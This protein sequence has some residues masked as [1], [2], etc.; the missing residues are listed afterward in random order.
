MSAGGGGW[1]PDPWERHEQRWHNGREWTTTVLD[2]GVRSDESVTAAVPVL[3]TLPAAA[4]QSDAALSPPPLQS[5][6]TVRRRTRAGS[7]AKTVARGVG[8][9]TL[10]IGAVAVVAAVASPSEDEAVAVVERTD[11]VPVLLGPGVTH[12]EA[13]VDAAGFGDQWPLLV[14]SGTVVCE[15]VP[16]PVVVEAVFFVDQVG[17][18]YAVNGAAKA[19]TETFDWPDIESIWREH[20]SGEDLRMNIGPLIDAGR[21]ICEEA[22]VTSE[23]TPADLISASVEITWQS[24]T[25]EDRRAQC[26]VWN[27]DPEFARSAFLG[28]SPELEDY[29]TALE[30]LLVRDC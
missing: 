11:V 17:T 5:H 16:G 25:L 30:A 20:P 22:E 10:L 6:A 18:V 29:W 14:E 21:E 8:G 23:P 7:A 3:P 13:P 19:R 12:R 4:E 26:A 9:L 1:Y 24:Q 2:D 15:A 27:L 28:D